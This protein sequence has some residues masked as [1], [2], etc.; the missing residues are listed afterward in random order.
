MAIAL[1]AVGNLYE[2]TA[3]TKDKNNKNSFSFANSF[4]EQHCLDLCR[5]EI[6]YAA[7]RLATELLIAKSVASLN[8]AT[9]GG[10]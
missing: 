7:K 6:V 1:S 2:S 5:Q 9:E 4:A 10:R 8:P 3:M